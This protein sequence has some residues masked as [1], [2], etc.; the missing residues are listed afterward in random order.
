MAK[1]WPHINI[2]PQ[3]M[4]KCLFAQVKIWQITDK[5]NGAFG[6][7]MLG[8]QNKRLVVKLIASLF[9]MRYDFLSLQDNS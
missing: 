3:R 1:G 4:R 6:L 9:K 7:S 8:P 2:A 5:N